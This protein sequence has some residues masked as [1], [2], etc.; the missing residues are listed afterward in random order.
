VP[1]QEV[2]IINKA[3]D[4]NEGCHTWGWLDLQ[5]V[6]GNFHLSVHA[7]HFFA[8]RSVSD[9]FPGLHPVLSALVDDCNS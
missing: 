8:M 7:S 6:A 3:L 4:A 2:D 5:R 1:W 9:A